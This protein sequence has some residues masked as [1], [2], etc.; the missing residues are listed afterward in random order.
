MSDTDTDRGVG[1]D[2]RRG[3]EGWS[4][5]KSPHSSSSGQHLHAN[6]YLKSLDLHFLELCLVLQVTDD[7][8]LPAD[9]GPVHGGLLQVLDA[10]LGHL[11]LG[12]H[13]RRLLTPRQPESWTGGSG[14]TQLRGHP[15][16]S[17][18]APVR[19][20]CQIQAED[21]PLEP[22]PARAFSFHSGL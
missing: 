13:P 21:P 5:H 9:D 19:R 3:G 11:Q 1:E 10:H 2:R 22:T 14:Q 16:R 20:H 15:H 8:L 7:R 12:T 18:S 4:R 6:W 17:F